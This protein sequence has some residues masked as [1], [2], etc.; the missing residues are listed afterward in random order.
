L[1][2]LGLTDKPTVSTVSDVSTR[3][4]I[5]GAHDVDDP[6]GRRRVYRVA[7]RAAVGAALLGGGPV[8]GIVMPGVGARRG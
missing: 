5:G 8:A 1:G 3:D 7:T 4:G 6:I 2:R